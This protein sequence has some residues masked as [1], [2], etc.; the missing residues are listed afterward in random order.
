MKKYIY[1]DTSSINFI[2][3]N[4][5]S[6]DLFELKMRMIMEDNAEPV[7]SQLS[8]FEIL[9]DSDERNMDE[10]IKVCQLFFGKKIFPSLSELL[11]NYCQFGFPNEDMTCLNFKSSSSLAKKWREVSDNIEKSLKIEQPGLKIHKQKMYKSSKILYK[12]VRNGFSDEALKNEDEIMILVW[13]IINR[14]YNSLL[15]IRC[16][17]E[18]IND[19]L[20]VRYKTNLFFVCYILAYFK[21]FIR[22]FITKSP[23]Y[24]AGD[25]TVSALVKIVMI[26]SI[27]TLV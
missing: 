16:S 17:N 8:L 25:S 10:L 7:L 4:V 13:E 24:F 3:K 11:E 19:D 9:C 27:F 20:E 14:L 18:S 23:G 5:R 12:L 2:H 22:D 15:S 6:E 1:F 21:R 26:F